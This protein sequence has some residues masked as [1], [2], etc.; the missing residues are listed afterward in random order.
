VK[1]WTRAILGNSAFPARSGDV[2]HLT[3]EWTLLSSKPTGA[4]HGDPWP[5]D[6]HVPVLLAGWHIGTRRITNSVKLVD[7]APTLADLTG[8]HWTASEVLDGQSRA[9]ILVSK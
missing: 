9:D 3:T 6:T 2:Y 7:L 8:V 1:D 4:S 5:Y